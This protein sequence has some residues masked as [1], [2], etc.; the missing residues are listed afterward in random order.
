MDKA[1]WRPK[2]SDFSFDALVGDFELKTEKTF[3]FSII[4]KN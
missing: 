3:Y 1:K 4:M 2:Y